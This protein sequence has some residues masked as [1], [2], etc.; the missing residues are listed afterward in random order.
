M[1]N[2]KG[3]FVRVQD[4]V[5]DSKKKPASTIQAVIDRHPNR[6]LKN[7]GLFCEGEVV[8]IRG[9]RFRVKMITRTGMLLRLLPREE[10]D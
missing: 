7:A 10:V 5:D 8:E 9:S 1:D 3:R 6:T 2:G 4:L